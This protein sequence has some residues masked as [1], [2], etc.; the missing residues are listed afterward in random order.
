MPPAAIEKH[1]RYAAC[2]KLAL[3]QF[4]SICVMSSA[5]K[6]GLGIR[7]SVFWANRWFFA[8]KANEQFA[9]SLI[10]GEHSFLVNVLSDLLTALFK[11][12]EC[13]NRNFF[14]KLTKTFKTY[15]KIRFYSIFW[16]NRLFFVSKR[17]NEQ[18]AQKKW[19]DHLLF[20]HERPEQIAHGCSFVM[21]DLS[22]LLMVALLTWAI[23]SQSLICPERIAHS[24]SFDLS[25]LSKWVMS[26]FPT[27]VWV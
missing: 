16:A 18:F 25:D 4:V 22:D 7:S 14:F 1:I 12:R 20:Y 26:E 15:I 27:L 17:V 5:G 2:Q 8:K 9:Y 19:F 21:S 10:F 13:A 3:P 6:A 11:K 24:H 23:H